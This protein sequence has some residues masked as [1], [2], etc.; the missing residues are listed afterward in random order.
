MALVTTPHL[1][2]LS[3]PRH[4]VGVGRV[5]GFELDVGTPLPQ[6]LHSEVA[7]DHGHDDMAMDGLDRTVDQDDITIIDAGLAHGCAADPHHKRR[8][9]VLDQHVVQ[10]DPFGRVVFGGA[11]EAGLDGECRDIQDRLGERAGQGRRGVRREIKYTV[12]SYSLSIY[13]TRWLSS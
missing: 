12:H 10:V 7:I 11:G 3:V 4:D 6:P 2:R 9:R 8:Q 5:L 13:P 1:D